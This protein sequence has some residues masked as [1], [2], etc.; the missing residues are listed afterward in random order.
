MMSIS[1]QN[2]FL[3]YVSV[4]LAL[5]AAATLWE[6]WRTWG[7]SWHMSSE[8]LVQCHD[9]HRAFVLARGRRQARC[10]RCDAVC[11]ARR[12]RSSG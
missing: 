4:L 2:G 7:N 8:N 6:W 10:P 5:L 3:V 11:T 12:K 9:C 1:I